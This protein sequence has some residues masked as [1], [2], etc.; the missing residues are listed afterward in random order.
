MT[1]L[2]NLILVLTGG[3]N[4]TNSSSPLGLNNLAIP[5]SLHNG[6]SSA[7]SVPNCD[8]NCHGIPIVSN[9]CEMVSY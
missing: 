9:I 5:F 3:C 1:P 4:V 2:L 7:I 8:C 6:N